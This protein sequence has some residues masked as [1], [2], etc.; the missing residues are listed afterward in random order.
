MNPTAAFSVQI[1]FFVEYFDFKPIG[2]AIPTSCVMLEFSFTFKQSELMVVI[3][4]DRSMCVKMLAA[5]EF[6]RPFLYYVLYSL[7]FAVHSRK[8]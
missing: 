8:R 6:S 1:I 7:L 4:F 5:L 3:S 2:Y